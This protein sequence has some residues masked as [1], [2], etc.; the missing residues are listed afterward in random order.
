MRVHLRCRCAV[1]VHK[2]TQL[3]AMQGADLIAGISATMHSHILRFFD[4]HATGNRT[5]RAW[6]FCCSLITACAAGC[7]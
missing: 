7:L 3:L 1:S 4:Q 5:L 6:G 2:A